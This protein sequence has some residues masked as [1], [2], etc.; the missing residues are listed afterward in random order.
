MNRPA[1][2]TPP[3]RPIG[4]AGSFRNFA[5]AANDNAGRNVPCGVSKNSGMAR[6]T[7]SEGSWFTCTWPIPAAT[8]RNGC[9]DVRAFERERRLAVLSC[10]ATSS[11]LRRGPRCRR[12]GSR[13]RTP[14]RRPGSRDAVENTTSNTMTAAP[15]SARRSVSSAM[16]ERGHGSGSW[17]WLMDSRSIPTTTTR[18]SVGAPGKSASVARR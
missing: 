16:R 14:G 10:G 2:T 7:P 3:G 9:V 12:A 13:R 6:T 11:L 15:A 8:F 17:N 1:P 18:S 5:T 4:G